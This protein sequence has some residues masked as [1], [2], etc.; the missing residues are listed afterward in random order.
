M[1]KR[2]LVVGASKGIGNSLAKMLTADG[3]TVIAISRTEGELAGME[4]VDFQTYDVASDEPLPTIEGIIDGVVYCPGSINL[5]PFNRLTETDFVSDMQINLLGAVRVIQHYLPNLKISE[6]GSIVLFSTVAV[7]TGMGFHASVSAAKGAVEG[8]TRALAAEFAPKIRVNCIAPSLT[9]TPLAEKL[10]NTPEKRDA[11]AA[12]HPLKKVGTAADI[13]EMAAFLLSEKS[14]W[15][16][17]QILHV[18]GGMGS[19]R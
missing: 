12:R 18:D 14:A 7:Q 19:V 1:Q 11:S 4:G 15:I 3:N 5:R 9:D 10:L 6:N 17:G 13:A 16:T 8:L 2:Y